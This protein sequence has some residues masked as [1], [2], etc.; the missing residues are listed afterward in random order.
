[1]AFASEERKKVEALK[2][3]ESITF[4][5]KIYLKISRMC[6][7]L[8]KNERIDRGLSRTDITYSVDKASAKKGHFNVIRRL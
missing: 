6:A 2:K 4:P 1:M 5:E 3:G 7:D 8:N